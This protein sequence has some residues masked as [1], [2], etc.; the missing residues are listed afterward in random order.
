[1]A[2]ALVIFSPVSHFGNTRLGKKRNQN[3]FPVEVIGSDRR[4]FCVTL[5]KNGA[6]LL[7]MRI[8]FW[9]DPKLSLPVVDDLIFLCSRS[10]FLWSFQLGA[11]Q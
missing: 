10:L 9:S 4:V 1:V 3:L 7:L 5:A 2:F 8:L 11:V 6:L